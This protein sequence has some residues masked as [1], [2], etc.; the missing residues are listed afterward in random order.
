[1]KDLDTDRVENIAPLLV[2]LLLSGGMTYS[3]V[4]RAAIGTNRAENAISL[5]LFTGIYLATAYY[6]VV[7]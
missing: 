5:L 3:T 2:K 7:A 1:L 4:A 6:A